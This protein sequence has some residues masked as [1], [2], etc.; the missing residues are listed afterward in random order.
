[1]SPRK[2]SAKL[3]EK[4]RDAKK[5]E[6]NETVA[7]AIEFP[8]PTPEF[9]TA[10]DFVKAMA[11]KSNLIQVGSE[12]LSN[13]EAK[14]ASVRARMFETALEYLYGKPAAAQPAEAPAV[15]IIWDMPGPDRERTPE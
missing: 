2:R 15:Q 3:A 6:P 1:M 4:L 10:R 9:A 8:G 13:G 5:P 7:I 12:L 11:E 14:G